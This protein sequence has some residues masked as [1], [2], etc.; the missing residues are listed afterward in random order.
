MGEAAW[1]F[2]DARVRVFDAEQHGIHYM[3][4]HELPALWISCPE[5]AACRRSGCRYRRLLAATPETPS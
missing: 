1:P 3:L 4:L 2:G 5:L